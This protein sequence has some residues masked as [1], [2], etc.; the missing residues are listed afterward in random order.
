VALR[1]TV[2]GVKY[3]PIVITGG[4]NHIDAAA[5]VNPNGSLTTT[6]SRLTRC[7]RST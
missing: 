3:L 5:T 7:S 6:G 2:P 4:G 1:S